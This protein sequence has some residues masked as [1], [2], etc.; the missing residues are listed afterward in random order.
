M[1]EGIVSFFLILGFALAGC[2]A[3]DD[4]DSALA[5][6]DV[7]DDDA[8]DDDA[9]DDDAADDDAAD[10]DAA[11][12]D[13]GG[14]DVEP[15]FHG[16]SGGTGGTSCPSGCQESAGGVNFHV[17]AP[18]SYQPGTP[19]PLL[20]VYS[21]TEGG[22]GMTSNLTQVAAYCGIGD[23]L[24]AVLDGWVYNGDAQAGATV[25]DD[26]RARYNVDNDRT[27]LLSESAGTT[28]GLELGFHVRQS[29]FAAFWANDVNEQ[30]TPG[31]TAA[32]LGFEPWGN[33]GPGGDYPDANAIV[34]GMEAAGYRLPADAP[35]SGTGA[36]QHGSTEQ[37]L[38]AVEFFAGKSR[39]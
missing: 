9:A 17:I 28:A 1:R 5:D 14:G 32:Q 12:D 10:D 19:T 21:G 23:A 8:A 22:A 35:Y 24:I 13:T 25:L 39:L 2:P 11:D 18:N 6:D 7:A 16:S 37:F 36:G 15:P 4:D 30:D 29:Y 33:A 27:W 31:Q 20:L 38:A 34:A 3:G 26:M